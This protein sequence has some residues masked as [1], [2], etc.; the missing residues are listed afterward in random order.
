[1]QFTEF[2]AECIKTES[3]PEVLGVNEQYLYVAM[4]LGYQVTNFLDRLKK[5]AFYN[6]VIPEDALASELD[7]IIQTSAFLDKHAESAVDREADL[8]VRFADSEGNHTEVPFDFSKVDKRVVHAFIGSFT[9]SGELLKALLSS[10]SEDK[11]IDR[12]NVSE[13]FGDMDW[14]KAIAFDALELSET[15]SRNAVIAKLRKRYESGKFSQAAAINRD[16]AA[17]V[18]ILTNE[19]L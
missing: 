1:M 17:E 16:V 13:E 15:S 6:K 19:T 7:G 5:A 4:C 3:R 14:Y 18:E 9:E 11:P 2:K 8:D 12:V 10:L